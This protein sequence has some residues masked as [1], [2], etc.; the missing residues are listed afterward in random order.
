MQRKIVV[1]TA[2]AV[3]T[4]LAVLAAACAPASAPAPTSAPAAAPK[5][6]A[7]SAPAVAPTTAPGA[8]PTTPPAVAKPA[9][10]PKPAV[11]ASSGPV[12][13]A[14][15]HWQGNYNETLKKIFDAFMKENPNITVEISTFPSNQYVANVAGSVLAGEGSDVFTSFPGAQFTEFA[16]ANVYLDLSNEPYMTTIDRG[17]STPG[18]WDGKQ[19]AIPYSLVYNDPIVNVGLLE[20]HG[21]LLPTNWSST[22]Q[23][24][25]DAK[26]KGTTAMVY[27]GPITNSQMMNTMLMNEAPDEQI[28]AKLE[29]GETKLSDGWWVNTLTR[30]KELL[31]TGCFQDGALGTQDAAAVALFSQETGIML[32]T[33]SYHMSNAR[34]QNPN[35]KLDLW[36]PITKDN[37]SEVTWQGVH[38][39]TYMLGI[40]AKG[41]HIPEAKAL[42]AW[43]LRKDMGELYARET[44]QMLPIQGLSYDTTDLQTVQKWAANRKTRF[45]PR[46]LLTVNEIDLAMRASIDRVMAGTHAPQASAD[47]AQQ[48]IEKFIK[49]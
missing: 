34:Q 5:T 37:P 3:V 6:A 15:A 45:Q 38:T 26:A 19:Y 47:L 17:A 8:A 13:L 23:F 11:A 22:L 4:S 48:D 28:M 25:R 31:D 9:E 1:R 44:T 2:M 30:W 12:T 16:R 27:D 18:V 35:I 40:N 32:L 43:M 10:T 33:G 46:L 29:R 21:L 20:K 39:G 42:V 36:A 49:R 7:T 14:F 41:K 24:C